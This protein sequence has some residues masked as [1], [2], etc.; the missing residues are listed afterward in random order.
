MSVALRGLYA[1]TDS[2]FSDDSQLLAHVSAAIAGGARVIQYRDKSGDPSRR[3][4]Q[5]SALLRLCRAQRRPLIINDD[6]E[7]ACRI[8][9]DGVHLGRDDG[10]IKQARERLGHRII[11]ISC[12]NE[13]PRA[14]AA[15][16]AGAD[17]IAF[18][19]FFPSTTK[20]GAA[21]ATTELLIRARAQLGIPV[22]AIGGITPANAKPLLEAGAAMVAAIEGIFGQED[23]RAAAEQYAHLF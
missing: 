22:V 4:K 14:V 3:F 7:L 21:R 19:A 11:G 8:G 17:Y 16:E 2:R 15:R 5:A 10:D 9:A 1:I 18:G 23:I 20:P 6:I 12:Y 13:W